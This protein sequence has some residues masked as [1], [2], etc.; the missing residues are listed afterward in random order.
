VA[1]VD[2]GRPAS[3]LVRFEARAMASPIRLTLPATVPGDLAAAAWTEVRAEFEAAEQAMSRFRETSDLTTVNRAAGDGTFTAVDR[4]LRRAL[5]AADRARR[6]TDGRFDP[7]IIDDLERLG[8]PGAPLAP[9]SGQTGARANGDRLVT[10]SPPARVRLAAPVDLGGIGKGLALRWAAER[11]RRLLP[12]DARTL[13]EAGGDLV[14]TEP[15]PPAAGTERVGTDALAAPWLVAIEDPFGQG[16]G[17]AVVTLA[18]GALAT[19]SIRLRRWR[20]A[21]GTSVHHLVDPTTGRP[22]GA[23]LVAVTVAATDPA[24]AEVRS[25]QL[26]LEGRRGIGALSRALGLAAWWI[27]EDG[28]L[29]MTPAARQRTVWLEAEATRTS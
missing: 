13:L 2:P 10:I 12:G 14:A 26:F 19:S 25:K 29:E 11:I 17:P 4:R 22:G 7:R 5:V 8:Y 21:E 23:G 9:W 18:S 1:K 16:E 27:T 15:R 24:W 6:V 3:D 20:D 28:D